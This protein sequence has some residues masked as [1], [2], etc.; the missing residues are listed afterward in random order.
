MTDPTMHE[1]STATRVK[2]SD[3]VLFQEL[4][5]E[6]VLLE[7][8]TGVYFGL[9]KVGTRVWQ[10][11]GEQATLGGVVEAM[12][13]EFDVSEERCTEDVLTLVERLKEQGLLTTK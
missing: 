12:M 3:E 10:L 9:D 6:A 2:I 7:L 5:G 11:L 8:K 13:H 4:Q 1:V